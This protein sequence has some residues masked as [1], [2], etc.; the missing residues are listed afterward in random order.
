MIALSLDS[1]EVR[2]LPSTGLLPPLNEFVAAAPQLTP[3][4]GNGFASDGEG[5]DQ[6]AYPRNRLAAATTAP[7]DAAMSLYQSPSPN[8]QGIIAILI[9]L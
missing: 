1:L 3:P 7:T 4:I 2:S 6:I 5:A 9:G 8:R